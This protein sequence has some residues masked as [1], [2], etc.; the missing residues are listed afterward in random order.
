MT[1]TH[2]AKHLLATLGAV[3]V[4]A[5]VVGGISGLLHVLAGVPPTLRARSA[6]VAQTAAGPV[7][8]ASL[9]L[10]TY[11][12]SLAGEHGSGGGAHPDWVSYGPTSNLWVPAHALVTVTIR[13]YDGA[14]A[15]ADPFYGRVQGTV[16]GVA[17][18]NGRPIR[19]LAAS[20]VAHTFTI[21]MFPLP[22]QPELDVSVPLPGV[23]P[24]APTLRNGYQAPVVVT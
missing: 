9:T 21:H 12:D 1:E 2:P 16:G 20:Q 17:W 6:G 22:G 19:G 4:S 8:R 10:S 13:N 14:T 24:H 11:P 18:V 5:V 15:L 3:V 7:A 23:S